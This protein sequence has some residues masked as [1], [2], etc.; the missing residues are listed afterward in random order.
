[1]WDKKLMGI[2]DVK[3]NVQRLKIAVNY[4]KHLWQIFAPWSPGS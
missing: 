4:E 2:S 1:M 3:S